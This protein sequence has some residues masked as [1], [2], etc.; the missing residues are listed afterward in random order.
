MRRKEI[1]GEIVWNWLPEKGKMDL[2]MEE[3]TVFATKTVHLI[4]EKK[5]LLQ[6]GIIGK[7]TRNIISH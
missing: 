3:E 6:N 5:E 1:S 2:G 7:I 4:N